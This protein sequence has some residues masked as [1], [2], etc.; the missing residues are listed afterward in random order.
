MPCE[1]YPEGLVICR[2]PIQPAIMWTDRI[3]LG[4][5]KRTMICH[6][7]IQPFDFVWCWRCRKKRWAARC[8]RLGGG[9]YDPQFYCA[10]GHGCATNR[11]R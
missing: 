9:W 3:E 2:S 10:P 4:T 7:Q 6:S 5:G 8:D 11:H 1:Y